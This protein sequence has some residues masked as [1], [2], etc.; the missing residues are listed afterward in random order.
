MFVLTVDQV[1]SRH[2]ADAVDDAGSD[3]RDRFGNR[4]VLGPDR[5]AGDEFELLVASAP[6]A[7]DAALHLLREGRWSVGVGVGAVDRP[8]PPT[9]REGAGSAFVAARA[10]VEAAKRSEHRFAL[11][12]GRPDAPVGREGVLALIELVLRL[13]GERSAAGWQVADLLQSEPTQAAV[14]KRLGITPQAVSLRTRAAAVRAELAALPALGNLLAGLDPDAGRPR[15]A[16]PQARGPV[17]PL[18]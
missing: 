15:G 14:A 3:L 5:T 6:V 12:G 13:R 18:P 16:T 1:D 7:L 8:L 2:S 17:A 9:A 11:L 10:A 4:I